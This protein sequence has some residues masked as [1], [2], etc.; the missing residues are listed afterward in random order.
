VKS[1]AELKTYLRQK[2]PL[3]TKI[4]D[5]SARAFL[6]NI[7]FCKGEDAKGLAHF[8]A[9]QNAP[10][11]KKPNLLSCFFKIRSNFV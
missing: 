6:K 9:A 1:K 11:T 5:F 7:N 8:A 10:N 4:K 3:K 2:L